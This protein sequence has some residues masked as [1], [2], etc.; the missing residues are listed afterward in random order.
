M[1]EGDQ[2]NIFLPGFGLD[3]F[4]AAIVIIASA[5]SV[6]SYC[7]L[8]FPFSHGASEPKPGLRPPWVWSS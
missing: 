3:L 2:D 1:K 6:A 7:G 4:Y 5:I 8:A